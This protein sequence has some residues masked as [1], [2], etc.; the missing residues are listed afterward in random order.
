MSRFIPSAMRKFLLTLLFIAQIPQAF[1]QILWSGT[2][3]GMSVDQV[4]KIHPDATEKIDKP[5]RLDN[6]AVEKLQVKRV[7][8]EGLDFTVSFY[9]K[10]D[11]L[12]QVTTASKDVPTD[13]AVYKYR[14]LSVALK[15]KYGEEIA[16]KFDAGKLG[17]T[18]SS[19][20]SSGR[21]T[22]NLSL[23]A[24]GAGPASIYIIYNST[25]ASTADKL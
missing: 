21:S 6:G 4:L 17:T 8:I 1:A 10:D 25:L 5:G 3:T 24:F 7:E 16:K 11:K 18:A 9:F 13:S 2:L 19:T 14:A 20:W 15:S 23:F 12:T 22:I